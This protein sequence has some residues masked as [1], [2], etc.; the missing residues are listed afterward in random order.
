MI[1]RPYGW[2][3]RGA[4]RWENGYSLMPGSERG[5][6]LSPEGMH[7]TG[8]VIKPHR[9]SPEGMHNIAGG[10]N[11][12]WQSIQ[13]IPSPGGTAQGDCR[14]YVVPSGLGEVNGVY[15]GPVVETTGCIIMPRWGRKPVA[16]ETTTPKSRRDGTGRISFVCRP[17]GT[18]GVMG[19]TGSGG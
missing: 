2:S 8:F 6:R 10:F 3:G 18:R 17:F 15:R 1:I 12:R 9:L 4:W 13:Q 11:H 16:I 19:C 5:F 7:N 14:L